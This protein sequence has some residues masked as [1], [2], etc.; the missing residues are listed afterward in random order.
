MGLRAAQAAA[1]GCGHRGRERRGGGAGRMAHGD[2]CQ[3]VEAARRVAAGLLAR[4]CPGWVHRG[5]LGRRER[6]L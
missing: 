6:L 3:A 4:S 1:W 5:G 2:G